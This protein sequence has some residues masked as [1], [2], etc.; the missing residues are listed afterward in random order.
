MGVGTIPD[1]SLPRVAQSAVV[2]QRL[3][4]LLDPPIGFAHR[5]ARDRAPENTIE[6]FRTALELGATGLESD[7]WLTADGVAVLD[8]DGVVRLGRRRRPIGTCRPTSC[9]ST[10]RR[11]AGCSTS[12]GRTSTSLSTS[13]TAGSAPRSSTW[14]AS[15]DSDLLGRLWLCASSVAELVALRPVNAAVRLVHSTRLS[16]LGDG[17]ERA[18]AVLAEAGIDAINLHYT[19]WSGGLVALFHRFERIAF[20]WDLQYDHVL[21]PAVRMGLDGVYSDHVDVMMEILAAEYVSPADLDHRRNADLTGEICPLRRS[22]A[23]QCVS[24]TLRR[25]HTSARIGVVGLEP[26]P[27]ARRPEDDEGASDDVVLV[28]RADVLRSGVLRAGT[29]VAHHEHVVV[30]DRRRAVVA[31]AVARA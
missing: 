26:A 15:A 31:A 7:V 22:I 6:A 27:V 23:L 9:P 3:P 16:R 10:S 28:D 11:C 29:V 21:H 25:R 24:T 30:G 4:S 13:S 12:A 14:S 5:G 18:A 19:D 2:Q 1:P 17:P 20:G 8:H